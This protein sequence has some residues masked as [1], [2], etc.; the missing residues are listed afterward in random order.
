MPKQVHG[1]ITT[2]KNLLCQLVTKTNIYFTT[3][4]VDVFVDNTQRNGKTSRVKE[5]G[6]ALLS[7]ATNVVFILSNFPTEFQSVSQLLP[8]IWETPCN[9]S[10]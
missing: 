7:V 2:M 6:T 9:H 5:N 8:S 10:P 3:D 1:S 4:D